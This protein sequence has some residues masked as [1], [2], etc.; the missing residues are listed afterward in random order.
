MLILFCLFSPTC[1]SFS[2][3]VFNSLLKK[4]ELSVWLFGTST[5]AP[6]GIR[7]ARPGSYLDFEKEK[8]AVAVAAAAARRLYRG[9]I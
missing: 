2:V 7:L 4:I 6:Y 9:L 8:V 5:G 1:T 3:Y